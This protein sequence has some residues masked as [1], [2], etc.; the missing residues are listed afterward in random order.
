[1]THFYLVRMGRTAHLYMVKSNSYRDELERFASGS[2]LPSL[3]ANIDKILN[4]TKEEKSAL[5]GKH[6]AIAKTS[7]LLKKIGMIGDYI[8]VGYGVIS[9][10]KNKDIDHRFTVEDW[11]YICT[12][13]NS[14]LGVIKH[15]DAFDVFIKPADSKKDILVG[16]TVKQTG[17]D[18]YVNAVKT[19]FAKDLPTDTQN[20]LYLNKKEAKSDIFLRRHFPYI[21]AQASK[22]SIPPLVK[23]STPRTHVFPCPRQ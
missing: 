11:K 2:G 13:I 20:L 17:K 8:T 23:K 6:F 22:T 16:I 4:G 3:R 10:H 1:M 14:P 9:H 15:N 5:R 12:N 7:P 18:T 19:V 21:T